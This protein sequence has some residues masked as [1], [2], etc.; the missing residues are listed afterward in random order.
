MYNDIC[1]QMILF[2]VFFAV[3]IISAFIYD[4]FRVSERFAR[5]G[6]FLSIF[7]D[8]MF[9]IIITVLVF[10]ICLKYNNGELRFFM[11]LSVFAG[12]LVYFNTVSKYVLK[13]LFLIINLFKKL[14]LI[15]LN[16][17]L[18]PLKFV[19][20]LVNKPVFLALSFSKRTLFD[21][22]RKIKFKFLIIKKFKRK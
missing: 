6:V 12:S 14:V 19:L 7:K 1:H 22:G 2:F 13:L 3:G 18:M 20:R 10:V 21:I 5:S 9:W 16:V 15:L 17:I 4:A 11:F 8:I